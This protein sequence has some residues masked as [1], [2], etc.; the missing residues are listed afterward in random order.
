MIL[1]SSLLL[2]PFPQTDSPKS[3]SKFGVVRQVRLRLR[4]CGYAEM[5]RVE[6]NILGDVLTLSGIVYSYHMKQVAQEI[7]RQTVPDATVE[8]QLTVVSSPRRTPK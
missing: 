1:S 5:R 8:N 4:R 2:N 6:V 7:A 3:E